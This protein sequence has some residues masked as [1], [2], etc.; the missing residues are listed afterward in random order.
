MRIDKFTVKA[1]E[2]IARAQELAS[3]QGN[4]AVTPV[5]LLAGLLGEQEGGIVRPLLEKV[6]AEWRAYVEENY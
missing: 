1:Q 6:D 4:P 5:H 2:S 3:G